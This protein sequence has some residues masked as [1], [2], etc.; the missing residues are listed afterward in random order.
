[1]KAPLDIVHEV[2]RL[3]RLLAAAEGV[4]GCKEAAAHMIS[5][6]NG[7]I[8]ALEWVLSETS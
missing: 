6:I 7:K 8:E 1:M 3:R 5:R 2:E 4:A